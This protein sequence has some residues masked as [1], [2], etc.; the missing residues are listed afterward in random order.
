VQVDPGFHFFSHGLH[1]PS[2]GRHLIF[3]DIRG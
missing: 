1:D 3:Y 2:Q